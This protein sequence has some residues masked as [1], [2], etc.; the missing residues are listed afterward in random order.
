MAHHVL[1]DVDGDKLAAVVHRESVAHEVGEIIDARLQVLM[2]L[3][4]PL[5]SMAAT[6]FSSFTLMN[7]PFLANDS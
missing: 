1:C 4:F 7:G 2:T 5:S 6:F 3:F